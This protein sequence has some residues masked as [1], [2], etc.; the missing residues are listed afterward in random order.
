MLFRLLILTNKTVKGISYQLCDNFKL[1]MD[2]KGFKVISFSTFLFLCFLH[3]Q[4][5]PETVTI[6]ERQHILSV[7]Y[8]LGRSEVFALFNN[9]EE[10]IQG[11]TQ[12]FAISTS[13]N[14]YLI[15]R[16]I[17]LSI[18]VFILDGSS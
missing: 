17:V 18:M 8:K 13:E 15:L 2:C 9:R 6:S 5:V 7:I 11:L 14:V 16:N 3:L 12:C 1:F 4:I 10:N